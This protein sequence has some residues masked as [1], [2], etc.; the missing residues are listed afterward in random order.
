MGSFI[1]INDTLQIDAKQ[2]FPKKLD[3]KRHL[4]KPFI[5]K[6]YEGKI[7]EFKNKHG[8]RIFHS[9]PVRVFFAQ[10]IKGIWLYWGLVEIIEL[11]FDMINKTTSGKYKIVKIFSPEEMKN[12]EDVLHNLNDKTYFRQNK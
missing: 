11:N 10:N 12:A 4:K 6:G 3:I 1:E 9:P 5:A 2:G 8:I 7:F